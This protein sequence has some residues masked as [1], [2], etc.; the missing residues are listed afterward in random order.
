MLIDSGSTHNFVKQAIV[1]R[2]QLSV[3][4]TPRFQVFIGNGDFLLYTQRYPG[5]PI[6]LRGHT[7]T[8]DLFVFPIEGPVM[9][10]GIQWLQSLGRISHDYLASTM[11]FWKDGA[12][13]LLTR[14]DGI[15]PTL[16]SLHLFQTLF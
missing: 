4:G 16:V 6:V 10:L 8:T 15:T 5:A 3:S 14:T 11:E 7:F 12:K 2:L 9:V 13:V 1:E